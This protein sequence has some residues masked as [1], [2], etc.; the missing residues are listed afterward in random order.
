MG[1][2]VLG[3][4]SDGGTNGRKKQ[5][6]RNGRHRYNFCG[7]LETFCVAVGAEDGDSFVVGG[8]ECFE[9]LVGLLTVV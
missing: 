4:Q 2:Y 6:F 1:W 8:A 3:V 5:I 7:V 9:A